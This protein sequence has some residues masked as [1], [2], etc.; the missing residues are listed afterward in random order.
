MISRLY[1]CT[2][3]SSIMTQYLK[4]KKK[5][6][7]SLILKKERKNIAQVNTKKQSHET[8]M[9]TYK[10]HGVTNCIHL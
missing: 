7:L 4:K 5:T 2:E 9:P 8:N 6:I 10:I 1:R 3:S